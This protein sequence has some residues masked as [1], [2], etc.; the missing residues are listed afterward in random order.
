MRAGNEQTKLEYAKALVTKKEVEQC[1]ESREIVW[2]MTTEVN[3]TSQPIVL[4]C[5]S[6]YFEPVLV[7]G[8]K[9]TPAEIG[10]TAFSLKDEVIDNFARIIDPTE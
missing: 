10:L 1:K 5:F 2:N 9:Y 8:E 7:D 4:C 6:T 3:L